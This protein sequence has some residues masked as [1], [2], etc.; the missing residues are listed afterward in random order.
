M[1]VLSKKFNYEHVTFSFYYYLR[2]GSLTGFPIAA[3]NRVENK[4]KQNIMKCDKLNK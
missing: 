3:N 4:M 1:K 2:N